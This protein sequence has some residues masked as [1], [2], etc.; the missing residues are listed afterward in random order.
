MNKLVQFQPVINYY[1]A[2]TT[3]TIFGIISLA[4]V[5]FGAVLT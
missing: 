3:V 5:S 4:L 2:L 1:L